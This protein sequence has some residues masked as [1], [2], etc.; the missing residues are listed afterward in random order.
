MDNALLIQILDTS[1]KVALG[2][3][4]AMGA[5]WWVSRRQRPPVTEKESP[6]SRRLAMLEG[7]S[8]QVGQIA[9]L[10]GKYASLA[11]ESTQYGERWPLPR[12][13]ELEQ[14]NAELVDEFRKLADAEAKLLMLG[15]KNLE[16]CLRLYTLKMASFRKQ[17]YVGRK[18]ITPEQIAGLKQDIAMAREKFYDMLSKKYDR[19]L[20]SA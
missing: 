15:E 17:V 5:G 1:F 2:A 20:V 18:D 14:I 6:E 7:I 19:L 10:F 4:I 3:L 8:S 13:K 16:R 9:H 12:K 11:A